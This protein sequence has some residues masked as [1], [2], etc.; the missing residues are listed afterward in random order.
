MTKQ[1]YHAPW[2]L[3]KSLIFILEEFLVIPLLI[4]S[5][6]TSLSILLSFIFRTPMQLVFI[7]KLIFGC[8]QCL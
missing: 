2:P 4:L 3:R 8:G 7:K 1:N 5:F 6:L